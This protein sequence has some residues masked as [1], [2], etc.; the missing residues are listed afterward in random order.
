VFVGANNAAINP[1]AQPEII[2]VY[3]QV[4]FGWHG[5]ELAGLE[6]GLLH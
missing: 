3:N 6:S 5:L 4:A 2:G 1:L